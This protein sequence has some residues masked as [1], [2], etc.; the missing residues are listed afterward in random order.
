VPG[1]GQDAGRRFI[2]EHIPGAVFFD[3]DAVADRTSRLPH[4]LPPPEEFASAVGRLGIAN[5]DPVVAYDAQG[6]V[7]APRAWWMFRVFGHSAVS[8]LDG[9][10]PQWRREGRAMEAGAPVPVATSYHAT[11]RGELVRTAQQVL[12]AI[13]S[14]DEQIVD[15]RS[16]GRFAGIDP[17]P[18]PGLRGGHIPG[19]RNVPF[20]ALVDPSLG[21]LRDRN[22]LHEAFTAAGVDTRHPVICTCGSGITACVLAYA[23]HLLGNDQASVYDGSWAEWGAD[24]RL[25]METGSSA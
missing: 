23:L 1:S 17:E 24:A 7:S 6:V 18:R 22:G 25:P 3:I 10:L 13:D 14:Q 12:R 2:G 4:M 15:A 5:D 19:S 9:G 21:T 16:A 20:T 8:V 11:F